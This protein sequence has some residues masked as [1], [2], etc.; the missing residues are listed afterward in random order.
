MKR[1]SL[2]N[3]RFGKLVVVRQEETLN[4]RTRWLCKCDCGGERV[5]VGHSLTAGTV[6]SCGCLIGAANLHDLAG[7]TFGMLTVLR[8]NR[9]TGHDKPV[10][11]CS[12]SCGGSTT[13]KAS[14]LKSGGVQS[15][16][17]L[18]HRKGKDHPGWKG[19][20]TVGKS[21]YVTILDQETGRRVKEHRLVMEKHLGRRLL[22]NE[23]VHHIN[24]MR[25][26]NRLENLELW[27]KV[28]PCGQRVR[29]L[30]EFATQ[31][32]RD[33]APQSLSV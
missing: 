26:D 33:Y 24:G 20:R 19:G 30:I 18:L 23:N 15:C 2:L 13:V 17:C 31:I 3:Q 11:D 7:R 25:S 1:L 4:K 22:P 28:Q 10:W 27:I 14:F 21:G 6:R 12:C 8:R 29:D 9:T 5:C 32:L 16:G